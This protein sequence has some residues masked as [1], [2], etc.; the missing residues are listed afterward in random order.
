ME[1]ENKKQN[2]KQ[3]RSRYFFMDQKSISTDIFVIFSPGYFSCLKFFFSCSAICLFV[4]YVDPL[5][6]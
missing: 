1:T 3:K 4:H 2:K 5:S 6:C